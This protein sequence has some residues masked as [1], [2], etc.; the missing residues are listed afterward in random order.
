M[1]SSKTK[2]SKTTKDKPKSYI[3]NTAQ[4]RWL[5]ALE[6]DKFE[7][8][9][10]VLCRHNGEL[11]YCC[12]GV[13]CELFV[14]KEKQTVGRFYKSFWRQTKVLPVQVKILLKLHS[15]LGGFRGTISPDNCNNLAQLNDIGWSFGDI[16]NFIR[17]YPESVFKG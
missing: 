5:K 16:A 3:F 10:K 12:L 9:R 17:K 15:S 7:Q 6:S 4:K 14:P 2:K 8:T 1:S 11:R 13:A